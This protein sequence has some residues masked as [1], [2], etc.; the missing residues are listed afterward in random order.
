MKPRFYGQGP[1]ASTLVRTE[2]A[3]LALSSTLDVSIVVLEAA[4]SNTGETKFNFQ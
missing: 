3:S 2:A 4:D 1:P